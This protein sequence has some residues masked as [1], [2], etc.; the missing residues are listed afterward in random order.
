MTNYGRT[1]ITGKV[2]SAAVAAFDPTILSWHSA[3]FA[4]D[5]S[6]SNPGEGGNVSTWRNLGLNGTAATCS[7]SYPVWSATSFNGA[8]GVTFTGSSGLLS[9]SLASLPNGVSIVVAFKLTSASGTQAVVGLSGSGT[10]YAPAVISSAWYGRL[11]GGAGGS[12]V[13]GGTADTNGHLFLLRGK[14]YSTTLEAKLDGVSLGT[15]TSATA[16]PDF[17]TPTTVYLG[18]DSGSKASVVLGF[19]GIY[20]GDVE[21]DVNWAA[22]RAALSGHYRVAT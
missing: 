4:G 17:G 15:S 12:A 5:P 22:F 21:T 6:W 13:S 8:P 20:L 7:S 19:V 18:S 9:A 2:D 11:Q 1:R 14:G 16:A 10:R 3:W